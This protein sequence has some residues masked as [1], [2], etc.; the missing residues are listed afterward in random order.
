MQSDDPAIRPVRET[1]F[2]PWLA[3]WR[4]YQ[5]FYRTHIPDEATRA[6]WN[7]FFDQ[8]EPVYC[9]VAE[10]DGKLIGLAH[11]LFHR[12]TWLVGP[13]CYLND[14]FVDPRGRRSGVARKLIEAVYEAADQE[15]AAKVYWLTH[16]SNAAARLL[17]DQVAR[18]GGFIQYQRAD[19]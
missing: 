9:V 18:Y 16:E 3:L 13:A 8:Q 4:G 11:Y 10:R 1:D 2:E 19:S 7:R 17:Y 15:G 14:L 6:T 5:E 12:S